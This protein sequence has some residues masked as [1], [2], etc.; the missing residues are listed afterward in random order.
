MQ[1]MQRCD[2]FP[3]KKNADEAKEVIEYSECSS[4][5]IYVRGG[6][7]MAATPR[8]SPSTPQI[9]PRQPRISPPTPRITP[10]TPRI[11]PKIPKLK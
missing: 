5:T 8:T 11:T 6:V 1:R 10:R 3:I 4:Q 2:S 7:G 9:T